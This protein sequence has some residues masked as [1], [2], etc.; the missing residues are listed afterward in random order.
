[1]NK[2]DEIEKLLFNNTCYV[3]KVMSHEE[4]FRSKGDIQDYFEKQMGVELGDYARETNRIEFLQSYGE[5]DKTLQAK[6]V[7]L[8]PDTVELILKLLKS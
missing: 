1:M 3:R 7:V 5:N 6:C 8:H 4:S 2:I